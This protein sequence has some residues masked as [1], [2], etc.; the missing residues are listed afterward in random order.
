MSRISSRQN[1]NVKMGSWLET[2]DWGH[3]VE[4]YN[5]GEE[6]LRHQLR[7]VWMSERN[8]MAV[9]TE[10]I[11][12]R[13][14]DKLAPNARQRLH[15]VQSEVCPDCRWHR[16]WQKESHWMKMLRLVELAC[17]TCADVVLDNASQV[18]RMEVP[19]KAVQCA[20][21]SFMAVLMDSGQEL[22]Q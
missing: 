22:S 12:H 19:A 20:L 13:Q 10:A 17:R 14:Y 4:P 3:A 18:W 16:Q 15:E 2:S 8:E 11:H 7:R 5:V 1:A 21:H 9:L 6:R